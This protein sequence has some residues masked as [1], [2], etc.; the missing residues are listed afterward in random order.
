MIPTALAG[1]AARRTA[2]QADGE[3]TGVLGRGT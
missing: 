2:A 3:R 1:G